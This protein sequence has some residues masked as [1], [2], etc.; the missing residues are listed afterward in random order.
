MSALFNDLQLSASNGSD[1]GGGERRRSDPETILE[2]LNPPQ[3]EAVTHT[4]SPLLIV[5][6]AGSG[7]TRVLTRRIAYLLAERGVAQPAETAAVLAAHERGAMRLASSTVTTLGMWDLAERRRHLAFWETVREVESRLAPTGA[8]VAV[9]DVIQFTNG[10]TVTIAA[11]TSFARADSLYGQGG[12]FTNNALLQIRAGGQTFDQI[13]GTLDNQGQFIIESG[14]FQFDGGTVT[15]APIQLLP[16]PTTRPRS[17][18]RRTPATL[19]SRRTSPLPSS[20]P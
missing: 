20:Q 12:M 11:D 16:A 19:S 18:R 3:R 17:R 6:G 5:A 9:L 13:G 15:G 4:G 14:T 7:K 8:A 2:G 1:R 10:G